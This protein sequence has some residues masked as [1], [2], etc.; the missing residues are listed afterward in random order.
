MNRTVVRSFACRL[1][2]WSELR[3]HAIGNPNNRRS[4]VACE[5]AEVRD[6]KA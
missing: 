1:M 6:G 3:D 5:P 2:T 4:D